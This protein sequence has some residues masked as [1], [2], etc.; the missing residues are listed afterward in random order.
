[1]V[2]SS[3]PGFHVRTGRRVAKLGQT[4]RSRQRHVR[5]GTDK[6]AAAFAQN[7]GAAISIAGGTL[8]PLDRDIVGEAA[9]NIFAG[10]Q[11][12]Y[13]IVG[14]DQD[15]SLLDFHVGEVQARQS[16]GANSRMTVLVTDTTKFGRGATVRGGQLEDCRRTRA[17]T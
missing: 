5:L 14:V 3:L 1:M 4:V 6:N 17:R 16:I 12:D 13:G 2:E 8:R 15:G 11:A 9:V 7:P 10:L